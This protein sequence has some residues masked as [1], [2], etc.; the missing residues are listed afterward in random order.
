M[1]LYNKKQNICLALLF[2]IVPFTSCKKFLTENPTTQ[3]TAEFVYNTPEGL[4]SAVVG[5]Y[6]LQRDFWQKVNTNN[7][8]D[9]IVVD[10]RDDLTVPRG[11]EISNYGRMS[12]G[13][14]PDNSGV[15]G[16]YWRTYYR[17]ID[18]ANG[19]IKAAE[20]INGMEEDRRT[21]VLAEAKFFRAN[22]VFTL[23]KLFNNIYVTTE[24]TTPENA[25][26][27]VLNKTPEADIYKLINDDLT[28]AIANLSMTTADFGRITQ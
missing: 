17:I 23:Y 4:E 16:N 26:N 28:Y 25:M 15:F 27:I 21:K 1:K 22:A 20:T 5:L 6:N 8:S 10:S 13:T 24:P 12:S 3:F 19:I 2:I 7:G 14:R 9:P 11:G 18:R